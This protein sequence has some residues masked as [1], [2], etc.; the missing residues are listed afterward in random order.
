M[1]VCESQ[2]VIWR[3]VKKHKHTVDKCL[4]H[5]HCCWVYV[6]VICLVNWSKEDEGWSRR[7]RIGQ[8]KMRV[9]STGQLVK[10]TF[11][12]LVA[13]PL[14]WTGTLTE[15]NSVFHSVTSVIYVI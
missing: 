8:R 12:E 14:L 6:L 13:H 15:S 11:G 5:T 10:W 3:L 1:L 7:I 4:E 2:F 9:W